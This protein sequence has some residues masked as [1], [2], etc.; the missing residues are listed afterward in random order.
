M[1]AYLAMRIEGRHL[2]YSIVYRKNYR[3]FK[4]TVDDI[5][6][7]NGYSNLIQPDPNEL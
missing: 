5:L 7:V 4:E 3:Q 6:I 1:A 2:D